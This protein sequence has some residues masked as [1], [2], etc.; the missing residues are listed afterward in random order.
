MFRKRAATEA[1][2]D[3][4]T[5]QWKT[6]LIALVRHYHIH[7]GIWEVNLQ[8]GSALS[9]KADIHA[10]N[11]VQ[12]LPAA[13]CPAFG[14]VLKRVEKLTEL[15]VDASIVNAKPADEKPTTLEVVN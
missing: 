1:P 5:V 2:K 8:F 4:V 6:V 11:G 10:K 15:A 13:I 14:L 3:E 9:M 12:L 7:E